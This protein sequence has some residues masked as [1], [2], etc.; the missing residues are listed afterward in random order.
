[1]LEM[2]EKKRSQE[3]AVRE[4]RVQQIINK[5][6]DVMKKSNDEE[7]KF[8]MKILNEALEKDKIAEKNE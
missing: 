4:K 2:Q 7:K 6:G 8:E 3:T 1:M 5:M